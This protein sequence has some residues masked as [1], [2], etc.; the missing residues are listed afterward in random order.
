MNFTNW[1]GL[2]PELVVAGFAVVLPMVGM[3]DVDRRGKR[4]VALVGLGGAFLLT[5]G[6]V[7]GFQRTL[8]ILG[9]FSTVYTGITFPAEH[10]VYAITTASQF[11][12]LLFLGI[13]FVAVLGV[14]KPLKGR[15]EEDWGEFYSLLLFAILG[16][17]VVASAQEMFTLML[18]VETASLS[19]YLMAAFRRDREGAEAG[20]K[21]F[22]IG[23]I[24]SGMSLF[25]ISLVFAMTGTTRLYD[26]AQH[27]VSGGGFDAM[28]MLATVLF[29]GGLGFKIS[30]VPF[31]SWAPDVYQG[32]PAPVAG[33]LASGS[34]AM[35]LVALVQ[36]FAV[37]MLN[38]KPDWELA[39]GLLAIVTM[40]VGNLVALQQTSIR[41]MLAYSSIAQAGYLMIGIAAGG[42]YGI[43]GSILHLWVNAAMKL[44]AFIVVGALLAAGIPDHIDGWKGLGRRAPWLAF[45]MAIFLL[46]MAGLPPFGGFVS[47]FVL[48]SGAVNAGLATGAAWLYVLAGAAI[49]SS[50]ISLYYY[51]RVIRSMY[52]EDA[53][54]DADRI[55]ADP[56]T[57]AAVFACLLLVLAIGVMPQWF[58]E[59]SMAAADDLLHG[60]SL[61]AAGTQAAATLAGP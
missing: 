35:G 33:V 31:H 53:N 23:A 57:Y 54:P 27:L 50:A 8:P 19:S 14:G 45:P 7:L 30:L 42:Y 40:F 56:S 17:M 38:V 28:A 34:K 61:H 47:K 15:V 55:H 9:Q 29:L 41:R 5:L 36:V 13:G 11:L 25:G 20:L 3:W 59:H 32:S 48:F 60:G 39:V 6:G 26:V 22:T 24:S 44:G 58:L 18:G 4:D 51:L 43:G 49:L 2:M 12:K 46:S 52:V 10:A 21:Y 37:A 1:Q 16:M